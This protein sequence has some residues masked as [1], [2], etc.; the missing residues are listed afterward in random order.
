ME[1][2]VKFWMEQ[3][4]VPCSLNA[5]SV[6]DSL[7]INTNY[8]ARLIPLFAAQ[9]RHHL[10]ILSKAGINCE[11]AKNPIGDVEPTD[12]VAFA[13]TVN[14]DE[15]AARYE[16]NA[17]SPVNRLKLAKL[18]QDCGWHIRYRIDPIMPVPNWESEYAR[19]I[20]SIA[21][22]WARPDV[23]TIGSLRAL[24]GLKH[25]SKGEPYNPCIDLKDVLEHDKDFHHWRLIEPV[26]REMY[27]FIIDRIHK[28]LGDVPV[29]LCKETKQ[30]CRQVLGGLP[31]IC[32]CVG[33]A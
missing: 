3:N 18:Y 19:L 11:E 8:L 21:K 23:I 22:Y 13:W 27:E 24:F 31:T 9:E 6:C 26:R 17:P 4:K 29:A 1:Q 12:R 14:C 5:G 15:A 10:N 32:N 33:L 2:E 25:F 30:M 7:A 20:D 28:R 16:R